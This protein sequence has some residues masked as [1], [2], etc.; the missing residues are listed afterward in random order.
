MGCPDAYSRSSKVLVQQGWVAS[1]RR[2]GLLN[3]YVST[4]K[5]SHSHLPVWPV[6]LMLANCSLAF[7]P[8]AWEV[9]AGR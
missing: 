5:T 9:A 6:M 2:A 1:F 7:A 4:A 8:C 3:L